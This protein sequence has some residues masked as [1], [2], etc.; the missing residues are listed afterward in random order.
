ME[1]AELIGPVVKI[2]RGE[3]NVSLSNAREL[4]YGTH[5]S[6]SVDLDKGTFFDHELGEGGG[7]IDL[8]MQEVP[9][10]RENGGVAHWLR[11]Q[12]LEGPEQA[13]NVAPRV[14]TNPYKAAT[15]YEYQDAT[16]AVSYVVERIERDGKKTFR[17]KRVENGAEV[18]GLGGL[19]P[20]P[21]RLPDLIARASET[22]FVVEGEKDADRLHSA[23]I[24]ATTNSGGAGNWNDTLNQW[25]KGR[26][27]V[28]LPDADEPG[29]RHAGKVTQ[30]LKD[31]AQG[32]K[33][34]ELPE[35]PDKGDV[36]DWLELNSVE[37]L[38]TLVEG[39]TELEG[40]FRA[41]RATSFSATAMRAVRPREWIYGRHLIRGYVS[42]T[43]SPGGA[44][45]T[46][47]ALT[48]AIAL[49]TGRPLLGVEV[50]EPVNVWHYNLED[51]IDE[52]YRRVWAICERFEIEPEDL[53]GR[54]FLDSGRERKLIVA[55]R[56]GAD[57]IANPA[58]GEVIEEMKA[59]D[60]AVLQVDPMIKTHS[61][62]ENSN[63]EVDYVCSLFAD[64]AKQSNAAIDLVHHVR[65]GQPGNA[66]QPGNIDAARGA[67]A[68]SGAVRAARTLAVMT[69]KEAEAFGIVE[70]RR[71]YFVRCDDA[72]ANMSRPL[73][74]AEWYQRHSQAIGNGDGPLVPGDEVG[75]LEPWSP[76]DPFDGLSASS[77]R[78]ALQRIQDGLED[79]QRYTLKKSRGTKR[80]AGDVIIDA[81]AEVSE[82]SAKAI[83][84][85]WAARG[86]IFE[87]QVRNPSTRKEENG[88]FVNM[89]LMP[90][91]VEI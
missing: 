29:R 54:L 30:H 82:V 1:Y 66:A 69:Q 8:I 28:V 80:W 16:G 7:V 20:L 46:T 89:E 63:P 11:E 12:G 17:Q 4:R 70:D 74:L 41:I 36:S 86:M 56:D 67:S 91:I 49:A 51:P 71:P 42:C 62:D 59:R 72:K 37:D 61:L 33:V 6:L 5:G 45:K 79:G 88:L 27:I 73:A 84:K 23:G 77:A 85:T 13:E 15:R 3:P 26:D 44:G 2:L 31:A 35:L 40:E 34:V 32:I 64:I 47:L 18:Y 39:A 81:G 58:V 83:L 24:L 87:D 19:D 25:F 22:V 14:G 60:I 65:K 57:L 38:R 78:I 68:L 90:G 53:E 21:Y 43:V 9:E 52:L 76:P 75:V 48:E 55:E 50:P 10:A